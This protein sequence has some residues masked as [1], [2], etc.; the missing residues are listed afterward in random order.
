VYRHPLRTILSCTDGTLL[1]HLQLHGA[2]SEHQSRWLFQQLIL[3]VDYCH[4]AGVSNRDIKLDNILLDKSTRG[5]PDWPI[6]K[7]AD[8]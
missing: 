8:W 2:L 6:L 3:A 5:R 4:T 7:L 1:R